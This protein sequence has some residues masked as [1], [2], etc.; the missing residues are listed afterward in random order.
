MASTAHTRTR[1]YAS[2]PRGVGGFSLTCCSP[3]QLAR[4]L[5]AGVAAH[6]ARETP[7]AVLGHPRT[8]D[9]PLALLSA[10][11]PLRALRLRV[12]QCE[13][14]RFSTLGTAKASLNQY[15]IPLLRQPPDTQNAPDIV[16]DFVEK[17]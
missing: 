15:F 3:I 16:Y 10:G 13:I 1:L 7:A 17:K 2:R 4:S 6:V 9:A 11:H 14:D 12:R 8:R 5:S